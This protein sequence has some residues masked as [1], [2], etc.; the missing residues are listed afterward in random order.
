MPK[1]YCPQCDAVLSIQNPRMGHLFN[2]P[3]CG[4][5]LEV[6]DFEPLEVYLPH[7]EGWYYE[8]DEDHEGD[9]SDNGRQG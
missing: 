5:E 7:D 4:M 9:W 2:C 1:T 3:S 6:V 8:E